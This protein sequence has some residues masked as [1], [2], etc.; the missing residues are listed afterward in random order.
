M[1]LFGLEFTLIAFSSNSGYHN[2]YVIL[3]YYNVK[4]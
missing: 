3:F 1:L 4:V 2:G